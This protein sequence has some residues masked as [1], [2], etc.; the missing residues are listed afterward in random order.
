LTR[1][2][3]PLLIDYRCCLHRNLSSDVTAAFDDPLFNNASM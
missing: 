3:T 1:D 2:I